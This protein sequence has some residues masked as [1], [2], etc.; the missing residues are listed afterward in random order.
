MSSSS[1]H[2]LDI[3]DLSQILK[4]AGRG[5]PTPRSDI[6]DDLSLP[7]IVD[8]PDEGEVD[9]SVIIVD[10]LTSEER[11]IYCFAR[12]RYLRYRLAVL[13]IGE[14]VEE[15]HGLIYALLG[16]AADVLSQDLNLWVRYH[17]ALFGGLPRGHVAQADAE[18]VADRL[19]LFKPNF[20]VLVNAGQ[21][22]HKFASKTPQQL[23]VL[24]HHIN[25]GALK[26]GQRPYSL[27]LVT[28]APIPQER[29]AEYQRICRTTMNTFPAE[30]QFAPEEIGVLVAYAKSRLRAHTEQY[31]SVRG[32]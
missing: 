15:V 19:A 22:K 16:D 6:P 10:S 18:L 32:V 30:R 14:A 5:D 12:G 27:I 9:P 8:A 26:G 13:G 17:V 2:S 7:I 4:L 3:E 25:S 20:L 21:V 24:T 31:L 23:A 28:D 1:D 11:Q 29:F